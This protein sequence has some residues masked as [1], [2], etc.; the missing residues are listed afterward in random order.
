MPS[1]ET[2]VTCIAR[3]LSGCASSSVVAVTVQA[4]LPPSATLAAAAERTTRPFISTTPIAVSEADPR[5]IAL[6][7]ETR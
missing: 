7:A 6:R 2:T 4:T 5:P 3:P 1:S